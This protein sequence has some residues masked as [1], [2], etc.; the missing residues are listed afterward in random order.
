MINIPSLSLLWIEVV[1]KGA[2][3]SFGNPI[4]FVVFEFMKAVFRDFNYPRLILNYIS[5]NIWL[6]EN[7][8]SDVKFAF[9]KAAC[10]YFKLTFCWMQDT[11]NTGHSFLVCR[12][13]TRTRSIEWSDASFHR[14]RL[15]QFTDMNTFNIFT[16]TIK[17]Y[18]DNLEKDTS[19]TSTSRKFIENLYTS[20]F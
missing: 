18:L 8:D 7:S 10:I 2:H 19:N 20:L 14:T 4:C 12:I 16:W 11:K 1:F 9:L 3:V 17:T 6:N 13:Q 15:C 5:K